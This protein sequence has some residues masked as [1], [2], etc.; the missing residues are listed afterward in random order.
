VAVENERWYA[1]NSNPQVSVAKLVA[2]EVYGSLLVLRRNQIGMV[3][4]CLG[5]LRI[6]KYKIQ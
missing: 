3:M 4:V 1:M 6:D 5:I 2:V